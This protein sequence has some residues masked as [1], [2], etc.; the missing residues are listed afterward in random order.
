[1]TCVEDPELLFMSLDTRRRSPQS[2]SPVRSVDLL[3]R[4]SFAHCRSSTVIILI[5]S[6]T[7]EVHSRTFAYPKLIITL[8]ILTID[9]R[10]EEKMHAGLFVQPM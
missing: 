7:V 2:L 8:N 9:F 4:D 5:D 3:R 1:M 10:H 6:A